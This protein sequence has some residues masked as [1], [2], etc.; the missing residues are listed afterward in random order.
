M[1][2]LSSV[3]IGNVFKVIMPA[4]ATRDSHFCTCLGHLGWHDT[5]RITSILC[6]TDQGECQ[7]LMLLTVSLT[8]FTN[9]NNPLVLTLCSVYAILSMILMSLCVSRII[10]QL[11][12][13]WT[14]MIL[15]W[16]ADCGI[17]FFICDCSYTYLSMIEILICQW[18]K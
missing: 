15:Y 5:D 13:F 11:F 16:K 2:L 9:V 3:Y 7:A 12:Y 6:C 14:K 10:N 1:A 8:N 17:I 18:L 4:T